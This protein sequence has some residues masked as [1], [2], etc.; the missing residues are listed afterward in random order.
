MFMS[1]DFP[2]P[3]EPMIAMNSASS[4]ENDTPSSAR[5]SV[6]PSV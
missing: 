6:S 5:T 1:V 4:T 3:D 2:D